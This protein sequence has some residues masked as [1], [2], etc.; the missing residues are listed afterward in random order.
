[1][2]KEKIFQFFII[3]LLLVI[4]LSFD[5]T[6]FEDDSFIVFFAKIRLFSGCFFDGLCSIG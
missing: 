4:A 5:I 6:I 3:F 1:M 2:I